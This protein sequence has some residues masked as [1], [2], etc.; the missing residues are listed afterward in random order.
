[1]AVSVYYTMIDGKGKTSTVTIPL[2]NNTSALNAQ[3]YVLTMAPII[4]LLMNG[5]LYSAGVSYDVSIAG[6]SGVAAAISDVQEK[7]LFSF[8]TAI[9]NFYRKMRLPTFIETLINPGTE[10]VDLTDVNVAAF[11]SA[12]VDGLDVSANGGTGTIQATT[13]HSEDLAS[14]VTAVEDWGK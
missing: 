6:W 1:M 7:A 12:I 2:P 9:G 11:V 8:K 13:I 3:A 5:G 14:L 4:K 10:T